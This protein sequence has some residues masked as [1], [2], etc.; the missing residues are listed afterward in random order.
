MFHPRNVTCF[1]QGM[2]MF[3]PRNVHVSSKKCPCFI[4]EISMFHPGNVHVSPM[5]CPCFI[6]EMSIISS[7][8]CPCFIQEMSMFHLQNVL[9]LSRKCPCLSSVYLEKQ[10][11]EEWYSPVQGC[12]QGVPSQ[13]QGQSKYGDLSKISFL[14]FQDGVIFVISLGGVIF[15]FFQFSNFPVQIFEGV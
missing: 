13:C 6:Q 3:H 8:K 7:R 4:R 12:C 2:Y 15:Q 9:V 11:V 1:T 5:K 14:L 10:R